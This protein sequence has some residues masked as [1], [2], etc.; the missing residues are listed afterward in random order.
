MYIASQHNKFKS[1][2]SNTRTFCPNHFKTISFQ[3]H[4]IFAINL[5]FL[6]AIGNLP[7]KSSVIH[8]NSNLTTK[9]NSGGSRG[10]LRLCMNQFWSIIFKHKNSDISKTNGSSDLKFIYKVPCLYAHNPAIA[11][12]YPQW[13]KSYRKKRFIFNS[14]QDL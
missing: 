8:Q 3:D 4:C 14:F 6:D 9:S 13:F 12:S 10:P 2:P 11:A 1:K 5:M 7:A